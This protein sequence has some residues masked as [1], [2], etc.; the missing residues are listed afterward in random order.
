[1]LRDLT[2]PAV[3]CGRGFAVD[4]RPEVAQGPGRQRRCLHGAG[5][6][7]TAPPGGHC[8]PAAGH[9]GPGKEKSVKQAEG[10]SFQAAHSIG[11][12]SEASAG[13]GHTSCCLVPKSCPA[14]L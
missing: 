13:L 8:C 12:W 11:Y 7:L 3:S 1:M 14:L 2:F 5:P 4:G 10:A 6:A 9:Q